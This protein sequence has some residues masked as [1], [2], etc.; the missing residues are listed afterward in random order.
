M[1][2]L[3][4]RKILGREGDEDQAFGVGRNVIEKE[5]A[6]PL[7]GAAL[8]ERQQPAEPAVGGA[9]GR[10]DKQAR[11]ILQIEANADDELDANLLGGE[12]GANDAGKRV[13]IGDG[14]GL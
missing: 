2:T 10:I 4:R 14:D 3:T 9:V 13:P 1:T 8:A 11:S 6:L 12:M 7:L 5:R